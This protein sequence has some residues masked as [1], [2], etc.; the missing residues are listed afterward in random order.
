[1]N[2]ADWRNAPGKPNNMGLVSISISFLGKAGNIIRRMNMAEMVYDLHHCPII[3]VKST[4]QVN[5]C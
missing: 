5:Y 3:S 2:A 1:M 4:I